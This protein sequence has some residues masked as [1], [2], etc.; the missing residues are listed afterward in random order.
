ME[1][2]AK[3]DGKTGRAAGIYGRLFFPCSGGAVSCAAAGNS[4][5][6]QGKNRPEPA[7]RTPDSRLQRFPGMEVGL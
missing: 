7:Q 5:I 3:N 2:S 4:A 6:I 1:L